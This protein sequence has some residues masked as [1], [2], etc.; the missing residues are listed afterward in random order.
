[1]SEVLTAKN[2]CEERI[3]YNILT[4]VP[5]AFES[6]IVLVSGLDEF[7]HINFCVRQYGAPSLPHLVAVS[8]SV[9]THMLKTY[10]SFQ[11]IEISR[12]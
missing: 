3:A 1:M 12:K 2:E 8:C 4:Y 6:F 10:S 7:V 5:H 11:G 9:E